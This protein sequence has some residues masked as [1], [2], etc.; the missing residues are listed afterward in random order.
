MPWQTPITLKIQSE[1]RLRSFAQQL[2][3]LPRR[4]TNRRASHQLTPASR[5]RSIRMGTDA[6]RIIHPSVNHDRV[7]SG[8]APAHTPTGDQSRLVTGGNFSG[9]G[10]D[11]KNGWCYMRHKKILGWIPM[12][13]HSSCTSAPSAPVLKPYLY[14]MIARSGRAVKGLGRILGADQPSISISARSTSVGRQRP[15]PISAEDAR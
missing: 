10:Y 12:I 8:C 5:C 4:S 15:S 1:R 14:N 6:T 11:R 7:E 9:A 2:R 3:W 13:P